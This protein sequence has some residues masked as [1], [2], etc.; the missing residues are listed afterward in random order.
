MFDK[1]EDIR[2]PQT[3]PWLPASPAFRLPN[4][5]P[6]RLSIFKPTLPSSCPVQL[7]TNQLHSLC[8]SSMSAGLYSFSRLGATQTGHKPSNV[9]VLALPSDGSVN[10]QPQS[11]LTPHLKRESGADIKCSFLSAFYHG[12]NRHAEA[13]IQHHLVR[14]ICRK[15]NILQ[16]RSPSLHCGS[17]GWFCSRQRISGEPFNS[18]CGNNRPILETEGS[19]KQSSG[20]NV[21]PPF[22]GD[23]EG[24]S[25]RSLY[26][27][28]ASISGS[29]FSLG[30]S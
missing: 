26:P 10:T 5:Q 22:S 16:Q 11:N 18:P 14:A 12:F 29:M 7:S 8:Y 21:A 30:Q 27:P 2:H 20:T 6:S 17:A 4:A 25:R 13:S 23:G 28:K 24:H 9:H 1:W 19:Q 3:W 15:D